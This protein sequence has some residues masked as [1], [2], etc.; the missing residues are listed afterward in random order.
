M[1][2][3]IALTA[4]LT[5]LSLGVAE[6]Q[7]IKSRVMVLLG[8]SGTMGF[9][10]ADPNTFGNPP[11]CTGPN[12]S[13]CPGGPDYPG[14]DGSTS[15]TDKTKANANLYPGKLVNGSR[16]GVN[17]RL[18]AGKVSVTNA[19]NA[20]SGDIDFGLMT[21]DFQL[22]PFNNPLCEPCTVNCDNQ[23][24]CYFNCLYSDNAFTK[25]I[26]TNW[27]AQGCNGPGN[28]ARIITP[29]GTG[30]SQK[31][32]PWIDGVEIHKDSGDGVTAF[33]TTGTPINP[34]LR[35]E[36][37][38]P[39]AEAITQYRTNYFDVIRNQDPKI[40]CRP[41]VLVLTTDGAEYANADPNCHGDPAAAALALSQ[42]NPNNPVLTYVIGLSISQMDKKQLNDIAV[43]GGTQ[44][45]RFANSVADVEAAFADIA[46]ASIKYEICNGVDDNCNGLVDEG[47]DKGAACSIGIGACRRIGIKKCNQDGSG[48]ECCVDD[49]N[50]NTPCQALL[51]GVPGP[52]QC[53][54]AD[55]NC[56][57]VPDDQEGGCMGGCKPQPET[58]NGVDDDCD[59]IIDDHLIDLGQSCGLAIG[60]CKPGTTICVP[61]QGK[62]FPDPTDHL[63]CQGAIGPTPEICDGIDNDCDGITDGML[64]VC[65]DGSN[66]TDNVGVCHDGEQKCTVGAW[67]PC[68]GEVV[69]SKE[70]CNGLDDDCNMKVDD[71]MG[72]GTSC[73]PSMKCGVGT[74]VAGTQ[75][76]SGGGLQ[77]VGGQGPEPEICDG[78]DND[79]NGKVDDVANL[80]KPC[81]AMNACPGVVACDVP[82]KSI[83]CQPSGNCMGMNGCNNDPLLGKPCGNAKML[84][85]PCKAGAWVCKGGKL[86][87]AGEVT[88]SIE[89]CDGIDNNCDGQTDNGATCPTNFTCYQ[90]R[91]DP[92]CMNTEFPCPG[93]FSSQTVHGACLCVPDRTCNPA[94]VAP[95]FC[96]ST[97]GKCVD[98]C[99]G[100]KCPD[101]QMCDHGLC[102]GCEKFGCPVAC[103][104]C[105][106]ATHACIDD[107]CCNVQ[108]AKPTFCDPKSGACVATC[109]QGC[110]SG[111]RCD[112]GA[113]VGDPCF[114]KH[115]AEGYACDPKSGACAMN[116]CA[117]MTC[118]A[119]LVCCTGQNGAAQCTADP[120]EA[121]VCPDLSVCH[122]NPLTCQAS[123][124]VIEARNEVVGAGGGLFGCSTT[125]RSGSPWQGLALLIVA[126]ALAR[127]R[128][129]R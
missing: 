63:V 57:G 92:N 70:I 43:N 116:S 102:Y 88:P 46:S 48:T 119:H 128:A 52:L 107:K 47:F 39:L 41:Y 9:H 125:G 18:Y 54:N 71:V 36:G 11:K 94:C 59:G 6:A 129:R 113:C 3:R 95:E 28:G 73:C 76:C 53:S 30:S 114:G 51:G 23:G 67:G 66:G 82:H 105:D 121:T 15:Y 97:S 32:L 34:E 98:P 38:T 2:R 83:V 69:P 124:D 56:N 22:C 86:E 99:A 112:N 84:P 49:G 74:C 45:A 37:N 101:A 10:F 31:L 115:C 13:F 72:A 85:L 42:D 77:C 55:N 120:C 78:L 24:N 111:Q 90:G 4:A 35:A 110:P 33:G 62:N 104:R 79:C 17:S 81:V 60:A 1:F 12:E 7:Q 26:P 123:C 8:T 58:C 44:T 91:C 109:E 50:V 16:D 126:L 29:P 117:F 64:R 93:G 103:T 87:C 96:D 127:R 25:L 89:V 108:C 122:V 106:G 100:V 20:Y 5:V 27:K 14:G 118:S 68:V 21:F 75:Q 61:A 40:D 80:G 19:V 65:Y